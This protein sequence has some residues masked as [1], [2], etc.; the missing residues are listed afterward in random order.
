MRCGSSHHAHAGVPF[1]P[2]DALPC[3]RLACSAKKGR[4][5][6]KTLLASLQEVTSINSGTKVWQRTTAARH[7]SRAHHAHGSRRVCPCSVCV[8]HPSHRPLNVECVLPYCHLSCG[9]LL[10]LCTCVELMLSLAIPSSLAVTVFS[11]EPQATQRHAKAVCA[12]RLI[13]STA[14]NKAHQV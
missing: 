13:P 9:V 3:N 12:Q 14:P 8:C 7:H 1:R 11:I 10:A 2:R 6:R 5:V 4:K